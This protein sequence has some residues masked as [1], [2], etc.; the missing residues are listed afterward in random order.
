MSALKAHVENG[1]LIVDDPVDLPEGSE[2]YVYLDDELDWM[3]VEE[4]AALNQSIE[5][6]LAQ[7]KA[8]ESIDADEVLAELERM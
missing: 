4:R 2:H 1:R 8:G 5:R 6:G 3:S 7:A